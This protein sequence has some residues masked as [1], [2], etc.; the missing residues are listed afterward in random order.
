MLEGRNN[1][2]V[3][4]CVVLLCVFTL[5]VPCCDV[6]Y[7]VLIKTM[8]GSSLSPVVCKRVSCFIYVICVCLR[9]V[10]SNTYCVMFLF[11]VSL[12]CVPYVASFSGFSI[13][14]CPI[15]NLK[16]DRQ[17]N[18][19]KKKKNKGTNNYLQY[20]THKTKYR[21]TRIPIKTGNELMCF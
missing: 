21:S 17:H 14:D 18:G 2:C 15:R 20:T 6:R 9:I 1:I 8:F 11:C 5:R 4:L 19:Q 13:V 10:M 7:D 3:V 16:K 12:S